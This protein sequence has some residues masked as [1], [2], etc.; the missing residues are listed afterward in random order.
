MAEKR[1]PAAELARMRAE[2]LTPE[3]RSEIASEAGKASAEA[4]TPAARIARAKAA[5]AA[6]WAKRPASSRKPAAK[7]ATK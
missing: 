5:V 1:N 3:R 6:R 2:S 7:K 4:L